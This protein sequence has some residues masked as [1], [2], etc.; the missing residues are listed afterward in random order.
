M[1][2]LE[3]IIHG[4][5]VSGPFLKT[6]APYGRVLE[7]LNRDVWYVS[8][9]L[10]DDEESIFRGL[11]DTTCIGVVQQFRDQPERFIINNSFPY[12]EHTTLEEAVKWLVENEGKW[13]PC[14]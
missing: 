7:H 6:S 3:Q 11:G 13:C 8:R 4:A 5:T 12:V 2:K 9:K 14:S 10:R 1:E